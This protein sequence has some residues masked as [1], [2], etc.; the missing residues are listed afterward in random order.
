MMPPFL[1]LCAKFCSVS[2]EEHCNAPQTGKAHKGVNDA[3]DQSVLSAKQPGNKVELKNAD[4]TPV[5]GT[6]DG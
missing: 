6:N 3:A 2:A 5:Q 1:F 4:K